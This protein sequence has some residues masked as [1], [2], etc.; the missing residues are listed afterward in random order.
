MFL[1]AFELHSRCRTCDMF[2]CFIYATDWLVVEQ[3]RYPREAEKTAEENVHRKT[4]LCNIKVLLSSKIDSNFG[5]Y[6]G[7]I[8]S[9]LDAV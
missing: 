7:A 2:R 8:Q 3:S 6:F 1:V 5:K 9:S 4:S